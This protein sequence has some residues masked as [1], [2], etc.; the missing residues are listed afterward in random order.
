MEYLSIVSDDN[1]V[2]SITNDITYPINS[3]KFP[4]NTCKNAAI[5]DEP[6]FVSLD[7]DFIFI[8]TMATKP[9]MKKLPTVYNVFE[10]TV[11]ESLFGKKSKKICSNNKNNTINEKNS[12]KYFDEFD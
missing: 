8:K 12:N 10:T 6:L 1:V 9:N 4:L 11:S 2:N 3:A 7:D 5:D